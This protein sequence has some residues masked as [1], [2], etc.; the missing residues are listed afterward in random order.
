MNAAFGGAHQ[1]YSQEERREHAESWRVDVHEESVKQFQQIEE[2]QREQARWRLATLQLEHQRLRVEKHKYRADGDLSLEL[3]TEIMR[4]FKKRC[5][6]CGQKPEAINI[7]HVI[8]V[9]LCGKTDANNI[10][11]ACRRCNKAKGNR[12]PLEFISETPEREMCFAVS[13]A[14]ANGLWE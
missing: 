11:P 14:R 1:R 5:A 3:W 10:V 2:S 9:M 7:E 8:P 12:D 13:V 4:V 6:Y